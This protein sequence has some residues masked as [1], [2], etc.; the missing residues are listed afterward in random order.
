[1]NFGQTTRRRLLDRINLPDLA[2]ITLITAPSGYG[3]STLAH[4]WARTFPGAVARVTLLPSSNIPARIVSQFVQ[5]VQT[6]VPDITVPQDDDSSLETVLQALQAVTAT[7]KRLA[8]IVDDY[9]L[10]ENQDVHSAV[11]VALNQMPEGVSAMILSRSL[12]PLSFGRLRAHGKVRHLTEADLSFTADEVYAIASRAG[13]SRA[14]SGQLAERIDGWIAG[15]RL[16]LMSMDFDSEDPPTRFERILEMFH[17]DQWLDEYIVEEIL[18]DLPDDL[19][20]FI[21]KTSILG[22]L[23]PRLC[24]AVLGID[25]S[26]RLLADIERRGLF[27]SRPESHLTYHRLFAECVGHIRDRVLPAEVRREHAMRAARWLEGRG[28]LEAAFPHAMEAEA[29]EMLLDLVTRICGPL[30]DSD[31]QHAALFWLRR[32]PAQVRRSSDLLSYRYI[33]CLQ[34]TGQHR[35]AAAEM[36]ALPHWKV[37]DDPILRGYAASFESSATVFRGETDVLMKL[38]R[39]LH[40]LPVDRHIERL[41]IWIAIHQFEFLRGNDDIA[42]QAYRQAAICR[43]PLPALQKWWSVQAEPDRANHHALRAD[44]I[45]AEA[46]LRFQMEHLDAS[47][48]ESRSKFRY[49]LAAIYLEWNE[50]DR[51]A[52]EI[53]HVEDDIAAFPVQAWYTEALLVAAQVYRARGESERADRSIREIFDLYCEHGG[54]NTMRHA[55]AWQALCWI[56]DGKIALAREWVARHPPDVYGVERIIGERDIR[57]PYIALLVADGGFEPASALARRCIAE[58]ESTRHHPALIEFNVWDAIARLAMGDEKAA[59]DALRTA[60]TLGTPGRF[61]RPFFQEGHDL[62][63]ALRQLRP[64]LQPAEAAW[65]DHLLHRGPLPAAPAEQPHLPTPLTPAEMGVLDLLREGLANRDIANQLF[66]TERT[67]KKHV[68]NILRKLDVPNRTSAVAT[69]RDLSLID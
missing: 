25:D 15:I 63:P 21:L 56:A 41:H 55:F 6:A 39:S 53:R 23:D 24:D 59:L 1:M 40:Y 8:V 36:D 48:R 28:L 31:L 2:P 19:G 14:Q 34:F 30:V 68:S 32:L 54:T 20:D 46:L 42:E 62:R 44:L 38:Y 27:V 65:V 3:K 18:G 66:I 22:V 33:K 9:H 7:G 43:S 13:L 60:I 5:A 64:A 57:I 50:L 17:E 69:A 61:V 11:N 67:V 52:E 35:E 4:Q 12:P 51:A 58:A 37:A 16:A 29:P 10:I 26:T 49:R 45:T 47:F